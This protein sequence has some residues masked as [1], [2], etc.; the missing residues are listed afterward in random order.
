MGRR[1]DKSVAVVGRFLFVRSTVYGV[2]VRRACWLFMRIFQRYQCDL[3]HPS[4]LSSGSLS[5]KAGR[6]GKSLAVRRAYV[7]GRVEVFSRLARKPCQPFS[8]NAS[9]FNGQSATQRPA[10]PFGLIELLQSDN[11][12]S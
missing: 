6:Q 4:L 5:V 11:S 12:L 2:R 8:Q 1:Q 3:R 7:I 9:D 10:W